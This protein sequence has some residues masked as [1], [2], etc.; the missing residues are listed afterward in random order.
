MGGIFIGAAILICLL[1][2]SRVWRQQNA[3]ARGK[4]HSA[5]PEI[6]V[7]G[8]LMALLILMVFVLLVAVDIF[9]GKRGIAR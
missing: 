8:F 7:I 5:G 3:L 2:S 6:F 1:S 4:I 9:K